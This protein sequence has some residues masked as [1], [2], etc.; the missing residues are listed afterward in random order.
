MTK[1]DKKTFAN[2][3]CLCREIPHQWYEPLGQLILGGK[4]YGYETIYCIYNIAYSEIVSTID[5]LCEYDEFGR[6][7]AL[8]NKRGW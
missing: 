5:Q 8:K 2:E 7:V 3:Y 4:L 1:H 6:F